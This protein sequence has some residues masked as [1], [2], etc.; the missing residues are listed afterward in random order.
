VY[1][2]TTSTITKCPAT[3]TNC[4]LGHVTTITV[5]L[6]TTVCPED[7]EPVPTGKPG[8]HGHGHGDDD[9]WEYPGGHGHG[10]H[11]D[12]DWEHPGGKPGGKPDV[13]YT[14]TSYHHKTVTI[15]APAGTKVVISGAAKPTGSVSGNSPIGNTPAKP[16]KPVTAGSTAVTVGF[17][18]VLAAAAFQVLAL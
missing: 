18:A 16:E 12:D 8:G 1:A 7:D 11:D 3:K 15:D 4:P 2:T 13:E 6:Y 5:P 17:A 9:D 10:G 14:A